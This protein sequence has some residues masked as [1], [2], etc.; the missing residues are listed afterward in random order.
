M[1]IEQVLCQHDDVQEAAVFGVTDEQWG[2]AGVACVAL[3][4][5]ARVTEEE[6]RAYCEKRIA[7]FMCP[8]YIR[9]YESLPKNVVGKIS[10]ERLKQA[11]LGKGT[12]PH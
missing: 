9:I 6:L 11:F 4:P 8:K 2:E 7:K 5:E 3:R 10:K 12:G 1:K